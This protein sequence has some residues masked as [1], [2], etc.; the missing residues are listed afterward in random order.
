MT[1]VSDGLYLY[2]FSVTLH[3]ITRLSLQ[4]LRAATHV[5]GLDYIISRDVYYHAALPL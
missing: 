2:S 3:L 4:P 1:L 5:D